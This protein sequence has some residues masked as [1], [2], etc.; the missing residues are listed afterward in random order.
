MPI[1][2]S[3]PRPARIPGTTTSDPRY[4]AQL[5][6]RSTPLT[7]NAV[8]RAPPQS[9]AVRPLGLDACARCHD[10]EMATALPFDNPTELSRA[11]VTQQTARGPLIN[12]LL[13]RLSL[14]SGADKMPRDAN[15][16]EE[17][18]RQLVDYFLKLAAQVTPPPERH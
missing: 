17:E 5:R 12:D 2:T 4:C 11:L 10:G 3:A 13:Y 6:R 16:T 9:V 8:P 1:P 15:L 18:R 14:D 7:A